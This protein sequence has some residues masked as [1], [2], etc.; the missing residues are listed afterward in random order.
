[1]NC[2]RRKK[3]KHEVRQVLVGRD[4]N[5][6]YKHN[7]IKTTKYTAW[8]FL[9]KAL[10]IQ[11]MRPANVIFLVTAI[12]QSITIISALSPFTAVAP[13]IVVISVSLARE[14]FEDYVMSRL[15]RRSVT[16][17]TKPPMP[18]RLCI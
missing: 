9:P 18:R 17:T 14:A 16:R 3:N 1:M 12:L 6:H 2:C 5:H 10:A 11:F 15:S 13:F 7:E 4:K 8:N